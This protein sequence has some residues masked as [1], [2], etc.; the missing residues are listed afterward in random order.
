MKVN[1]KRLSESGAIMLEVIAVLSLMGMVGAMLFRQIN[2]RNQELHNIQMASEIRIVKEAVSAWMQANAAVLKQCKP[3]D[4][5]DVVICEAATHGIPALSEAN[6]PGSVAAYLP[7]GYFFDAGGSPG[8]YLAANYRFRVFGYYRNANGADQDLSHYAL[9]VPTGSVLPSANEWNFRRAARVAMLIGIDGGVYQHDITTE[10]GGDII[11][12]AVGTWSLSASDLDGLGAGNGPIYVAM[13]ALDVFVPEAEVPTPNIQRPSD[14]RVGLDGLFAKDLVAGFM[15]GNP[16]FSWN[17]N[18]LGLVAIAGTDTLE[19]RSDTI[20]TPGVDNCWPAFWVQGQ[21]DSGGTEE[22][23]NVQVRNDLIVGAGRAAGSAPDV[24]KM[25]LSSDGYILFSDTVNDPQLGTGTTPGAPNEINYVLDPAYTSVMNDI[26]LMSRGGA[27]LSEVLPD[28]I[29]KTQE[30]RSCTFGGT[31]GGTSHCKF[32]NV[33]IP[34]TPTPSTVS[35]TGKCEAYN[36][37]AGVAGAPGGTSITVNAPQCPTGYKVAVMVTP[38]SGVGAYKHHG[39]TL[40]NVGVPPNVGTTIPSPT[41]VPT[42]TSEFGS[43]VMG[44]P[45]NLQIHYVP[46]GGGGSGSSY[47]YQHSHPHGHGGL[48]INDNP[49]HYSAKM[50]TDIGVGTLQLSIQKQIGAGSYQA[51]TIGEAWDVTDAAASNVSHWRITP[52]YQIDDSYRTDA[53]LNVVTTS[54]DIQTYCVFAPGTDASGNQTI[55]GVA[56]PKKE[57][58]A[59]GESGLHHSFSSKV[60]TRAL[61][62]LM[63]GEWKQVEGTGVGETPAQYTCEPKAAGGGG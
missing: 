8:A 22:V 30:V 17:S 10:A 4:P 28:Y 41:S 46:G 18:G 50:L 63:G 35:G 2:Q 54:F 58:M 48:Q 21:A 24:G 29:L 16:C 43:Y 52:W 25:I 51:A 44:N 34:E 56:L 31:S 47:Y 1:G 62:E 36:C 12:G 27:K 60:G 42:N 11:S 40:V 5:G 3:V 33:T 45:R 32:N 53:I 61:C 26:K 9:I 13:T 23:G 39:P 57:R 19:F 49:T 7:N 37:T 55:N 14:W 20:N 6:F 15:P 59:A 38:I